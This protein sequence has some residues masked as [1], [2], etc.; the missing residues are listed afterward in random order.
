MEPLSRRK[1]VKFISFGTVVCS[2]PGKVWESVLMT[3]VQAARKSLAADGVL[4]IRLSDFPALQEPYGSIRLGPNPIGFDH[5]PAADFYPLII[6]RDETGTFYAVDAQ[7][8][9][10]NCTVPPWNTD[11]FT[12]QC[13]CHG[14][15]YSMDGTVFPDQMS[16]ESLTPYEITYDGEDTLTILVQKFGFC[17]T[18]RPVNTSVGG[19]FRIEFPTYQTTQY[20]VMFRET[21]DAEWT[22]VPVALTQ[23]GPADT[24]N[25][26]G[27]GNPFVV[28]VPCNTATG[29]YSVQMLMSQV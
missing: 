19:R 8:K 21:I 26:V 12:I 13:P 27:T 16:S 11:S 23:D 9:H 4:K 14:S 2:V 25:V 20:A 6:S 15:N 5:F 28:F 10:A 22:H 29:F 24:L 3:E 1:F 7:C 17:M 18:G